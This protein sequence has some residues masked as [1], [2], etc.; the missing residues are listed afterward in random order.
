MLIEQPTYGGNKNV[1]LWEPK[2]DG[3]KKSNSVVSTSDSTPFRALFSVFVQ[4]AL[5]V[6]YHTLIQPGV[7]ECGP[8]PH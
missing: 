6:F 5:E 3:I 4:L 8:L 7:T 2:V 1:I